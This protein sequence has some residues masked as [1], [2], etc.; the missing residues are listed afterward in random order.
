[1]WGKAGVEKEEGESRPRE[2]LCHGFESGCQKGQP[3]C[4]RSMIAAFIRIVPV[5]SGLSCCSIGWDA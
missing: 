1:M 2:I 5:F 4:D 3:S